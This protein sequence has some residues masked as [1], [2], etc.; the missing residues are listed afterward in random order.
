M[1]KDSNLEH[2]FA[3]NAVH[4]GTTRNP[5]DPLGTPIYPV[6]A[7]EFENLE[8]AEYIF[9]TNDGRSYSRIQ[10]PTTEV[11]EE[12]L[13]ALEGARGAIATTTG[14]AATLL[15]ILTLAKAGDHIV[16]T[17]SLFGGSAGLFN[18]VFP[19][20]GISSTLVPNDVNAIA[21]AVKPNTRAIWVE[22]IGNPAMDVPDLSAIAEITKAA[23]I[24]F[25]VDNTWGAVGYLCRPLDFG[26]SLSVHSLTKWA[27]GQG[28]VMGGAVLVGENLDLANNPIFNTP[29]ASGKSLLEQFGEL[30]FL[31][32]A[33]N[34]GLLSLGLTLAPQSAWTINAGLETVE[35]RVQREC[36]TSLELARWL[37][38]QPGVAWVSYPGLPTHAWH[39]N[40]SKYL[41]NGFGAVF[42]FG[43]EGGLEGTKRF[44]DNLKLIR[45]ATN[46][47]DVRTLAVHPWT[48]THGRLNDAGRAAAGVTPEMIRVSVGLEDVND[49]KRDLRQ[50]LDLV[51]KD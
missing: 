27:S 12:R 37:E 44:Y 25:I 14:Q 16:A 5:G 1:S 40:A 22:I 7:W 47:G 24:P 10:N 11:L 4:V 6:I 43:I 42:T 50:A 51:S 33:R 13:A 31:T 45:K 17:S 28:A 23:H 30:A 3:T 18:N 9:K 20:M 8:H 21:A 41:Q 19:N 34:L 36:Q 46:L 26:A 38:T 39:K 2:G 49:L 15:T 29:D 48:T 32:R 35:V